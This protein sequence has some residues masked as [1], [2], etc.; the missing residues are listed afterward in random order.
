MF[1]G[2]IS[3]PK[4]Y[5]TL[6]CLHPTGQTGSFNRSV[7]LPLPDPHHRSDRSSQNRGVAHTTL[8]GATRQLPSLGVSLHHFPP[9]C[10]SADELNTVGAEVN[11]QMA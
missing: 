2:T 9:L 7:R 8:K 4:L 6:S 5:S 1:K 3:T 11:I 10:I